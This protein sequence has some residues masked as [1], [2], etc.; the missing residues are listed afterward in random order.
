MDAKDVIQI[1]LSF[2][3][4]SLSLVSFIKAAVAE[5]TKAEKAKVDAQDARI[6]ALEQ[7]L[8]EK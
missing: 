8:R 5:K 1:S 2:G 7:R 4:L 3:A 6:I